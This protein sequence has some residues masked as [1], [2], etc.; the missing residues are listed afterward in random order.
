M[1]IFVKDSMG[2]DGYDS[3]RQIY[4]YITP[5]ANTYC[6]SVVAGVIC[7]MQKFLLFL[8]CINSFVFQNMLLGFERQRVFK[9]IVSK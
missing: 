7:F 1:L 9:S 4:S 3:I 5:R 6:N 2:W 8:I